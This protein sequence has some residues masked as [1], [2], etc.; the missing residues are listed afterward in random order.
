M[1][2]VADSHGCVGNALI[3]KW[4]ARTPMNTLWLALVACRPTAALRLLSA[5]R[6]LPSLSG[7]EK[8]GVPCWVKAPVG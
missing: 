3:T 7:Q 1:N 6:L 4:I 8:I 5:G 2:W